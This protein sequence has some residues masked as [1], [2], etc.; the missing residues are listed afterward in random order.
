MC[1]MATPALDNDPLPRPQCGTVFPIPG[2]K[3]STIDSAPPPPTQREDALV[4][5][6]PFWGL[7]VIS[8]RLWGACWWEKVPVTVSFCWGVKGGVHICPNLNSPSDKAHDTGRSNAQC[9]DC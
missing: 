1:N 3:L 9:L 4:P 5:A 7:A 2:G 6:P 8:Q